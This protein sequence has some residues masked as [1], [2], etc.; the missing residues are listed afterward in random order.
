MIDKTKIVATVLKRL[1]NLPVGHHLDL[2]TYKR[3]RSLI[4]VKQSANELLL[5]QDGYEQHRYETTVDK[6][7][8][9]VKPILKKEFPRSNKIR[10]YTPGEFKEERSTRVRRKIL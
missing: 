7:E 9:T 8:K 2:R 5:I 6:F 4:I 3:N 10:L 1:E